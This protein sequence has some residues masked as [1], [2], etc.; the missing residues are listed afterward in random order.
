MSYSLGPHHVPLGHGDAHRSTVAV[1]GRTQT[2]LTDP[3]LCPLVEGR[4]DGWELIFQR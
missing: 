2:Y 4:Q 3:D 1:E